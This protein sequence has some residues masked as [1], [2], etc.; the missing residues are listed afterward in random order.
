MIPQILVDQRKD[1]SELIPHLKDRGL[2]DYNIWHPIYHKDDS[3]VK[4]INLSHKQIIRHA[5][6]MD[7]HQVHIFED[8]VWFPHPSGLHYYIDRLN[9]H[10]PKDFDIYLGGVYGLDQLALNRLAPPVTELNAFQAMH[11]YTVASKFY[12]K[13]LS[14]P[15][16]QHIDIAMSGLGKFYVV[17]PF[18]ALQRPGMSMNE[19]KMVDY[20]K[21]LKPEDIYQ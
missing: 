16:D 11:C 18:A 8:D 19:R 14:V 20:N 7:W 12:D 2:N 1:T 21:I 9:F 5:K 13:F 15:D 3:V 10:T 17:Y 6:E 4:S